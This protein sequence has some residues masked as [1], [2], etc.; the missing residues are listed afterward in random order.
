MKLSKLII[1]LVLFSLASC[2]KDD[3]PDTPA[4]LVEMLEIMENNSINKYNINW[5]DFRS[6]VLS[7]TESDHS[8]DAI[9]LAIHE[10]L[11]LL[12]DSHSF[13]VNSRGS[14]IFGDRSLNCS[15]TTLDEPNI[16]S[17]IGYVKVSAYSGQA[18]DTDG[19]AFAAEIQNQIEQSDHQDI[20][21]WIVD[22]RNNTGGNMWPMLAGIGPVLGEGICGYFIDPDNNE[23]PWSYSNGT[24]FNATYATTEL[25]NPYRLINENPK[26]AVLTNNA[27]AS[28]GEA[29]ATAFIGRSNT[30]SFGFPTCGVSTANRNYN[31]NDGS[32]L[33]LTVSYMADRN[34]AKLGNAIEPDQLTTDQSIIQEAVNYLIQ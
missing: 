3:Q 31:L 4:I 6:E 11:T 19:R 16:P 2:S 28:S 1:L 9:N 13:Y 30:K 8:S 26:V 20:K 29:I 14:Y 18:N 10:A 7:I 32:R 34:K 22:L 23:V 21:G 33:V 17:D 25:N 15:T 12:G 27:T 5:N 24:S